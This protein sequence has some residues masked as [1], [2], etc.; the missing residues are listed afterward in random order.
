[1]GTTTLLQ[2]E[3][4]ILNLL[5]ETLDTSAADLRAGAA[6]NALLP[7]LTQFFG[8]SGATNATPIVISTSK[9]SGVSDGSQ[10]TLAGVG[11][12]TAAN[13]TF[14]AKTTG[15][16]ST[17]FAL[18]SDADLITPVAGNSAYTS[19]GTVL[20]GSTLRTLINEAAADLGRSCFAV[21][22]AGGT[23]SWSSG[24][25]TMPLASIVPTVSGDIFFA[26]RGAYLTGSSTALKWADRTAIERGDPNWMLTTGTPAAFYHDG[27]GSIGLYPKPSSG[28]TLNADG[29]VAP[30]ARYVNPTDAAAWLPDDLVRFLEWYG[31]AKVGFKNMEDQ[32]L[33]AR[34][35]DWQL[36]YET[37][38]IDL[39][40]KLPAALQR[41]FP[42]PTPLM[43][44]MQGLSANAAN[45]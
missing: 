35:D 19:G 38:R 41:F 16:T 32:A 39:W 7:T 27:N 11:G 42:K 9:A 23:L 5:N 43:M 26:I 6:G 15:Y 25:R 33:S 18:Y 17:T 8:V 13:G 40:T 37:G 44:N 21:P 2:I 22:D 28:V 31:A 14:Y 4:A 12:N 20:A 3:Q 30:A 10:V 1:M 45:G 24:V 36:H 34:A 29:F